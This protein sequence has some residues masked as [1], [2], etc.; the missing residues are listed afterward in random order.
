[1]KNEQKVMVRT[2]ITNVL[3]NPI[4]EYTAIGSEV[5]YCIDSYDENEPRLKN[6]GYMVDGELRVT[7]TRGGEER[8]VNREE[9][10]C[11]RTVFPHL[12][13][14]FKC[15]SSAQRYVLCVRAS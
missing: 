11:R 9:N 6:P 8:Q 3:L 15:L 12:F 4:I 10:S 5:T 14:N 7:Y 1:M 13:F 2:P